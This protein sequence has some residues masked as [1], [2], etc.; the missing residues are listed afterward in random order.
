MN[1]TRIILAT[2]LAV[3]FAGPALAAPIASGFDTTSLGRT[4]DGY[5]GAVDI[6]FDVN[7][8]GNTYSSLY[9]SNNGYVTFGGGQGNYSP[10]GLGA[11]YVGRPI[12]AAFYDDVDT[13]NQASGVTAYGSGTYAGHTAFGVT[14]PGVGYYYLGGDRLD[15]FQMI[16]ADRS[17]LGVGDFDL[18]FNYGAIQWDSASTTHGAAVGF[19]AGNGA[20]GSFFEAPGSLVTGA[21]VD[22]GPDALQTSSFVF[23]V[24]SGAAVLASSAVPEPETFAL[25]G[26]GLAAAAFARRRGRASTGAPM[27]MA[28]A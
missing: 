2:A 21:F 14:W 28:F 15:A 7:F 23:N 17:D 1:A 20:D 27:P 18:Y 12:I 8:F 3:A 19:N 22:G 11:S 26:L 16:L 13:R 24:R 4:D 6:G 25:V 5:S 9:V 10:V